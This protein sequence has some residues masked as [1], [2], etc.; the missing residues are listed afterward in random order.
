MD[1]SPS[2]YSQRLTP[3]RLRAPQKLSF[4]T[5]VPQPRG[6]H[7]ESTS[8]THTHTELKLN[9]RGAPAAGRAAPRPPG[10][11]VGRAGP[12][13][14]A[15]GG[16]ER[17]AAAAA[18]PGPVRCGAGQGPPPAPHDAASP[19]CRP[20]PEQKRELGAGREEVIPRSPPRRRPRETRTSLPRTPL[21]SSPSPPPPPGACQGRAARRCAPRGGS[22]GAG[23]GAAVA[24][25][26]AGRRA[27]PGQ[28][29]Q[30]GRGAPR[31]LLRPRRQLLRLR[32]GFLR[33]RPILVSALPRPGRCLPGLPL[34]GAGARP[35]GPFASL[36]SAPLV[37]RW[38]RGCGRGRRC[39]G[40]VRWRRRVMEGPG[41]A[42]PGGGCQQPSRYG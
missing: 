25:G 3:S 41:E 37:G 6:D 32:R 24:A 28:R 42:P 16:R 22:A 14:P 19:S 36:R 17:R 15:A 8:R 33:S 9:G 11:A 21:P 13:L 2:S 12:A 34:H 39:P 5:Q 35:G 4:T 40:E 38:R 10:A 7:G 30:P 20:C 1:V 27:G 23:H 29:L 31:R 18:G 26:A